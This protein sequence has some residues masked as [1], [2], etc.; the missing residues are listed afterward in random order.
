MIGLARGTRAQRALVTKAHRGGTEIVVPVVGI[1]E[2]VR[3][4]GPRDAAVNLTLGQFA[5]HHP[6]DEP[7]AR[8]AGALLGAANSNST[9]DALVAAEAISRQPSLLVTGDVDDLEPLLD[10]HSGVSLER[11]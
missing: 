8:L 3:G 7:T 4:I 5:P 2:T 1:A 11:I 6:L 10:G 9:I